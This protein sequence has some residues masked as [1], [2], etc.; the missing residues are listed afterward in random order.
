[1]AIQAASPHPLAL[2]RD[3]TGAFSALR[4]A[5]LALAIL[6]ALP[7]VWRIFTADLGPRP[8]TEISH[9]T[10]L[11]AIRLLAVSLAITPLIELLRQPRLVAARRILGVSVFV[12]MVAH[13][14]VFVADKSFNLAVVAWELVARIYLLIGLIGLLM[15]AALAATSTD[16]AVR[17]L[18]AD[19]WKKLHRLVYA[20]VLLSLVHF[21]MQSKLDVSEPTA[22]AGIF[23]LL[24]FLR[25]PRRFGRALTPMIVLAIAVATT[26]L[27][28]IAEAG[29]YALTMGAP[30][31][32]LLEAD[33]S[34]DLGLRPCWWAMIAGVVL[35][36]VGFTRST[37]APKRVSNAGAHA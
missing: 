22:M 3:R 35:A 30:F 16:S 13:L 27:V 15:L 7:L 17:R 5:A 23:A 8:L 4:A 31:A 36:A 9:Q 28:A 14:V 2:W 20:I 18:G 24:G 32:A 33:F 37:T 12:W 11:W 10:G 34:L 26:A 25:L 29:W 21:F 6:P 19:R 1:M